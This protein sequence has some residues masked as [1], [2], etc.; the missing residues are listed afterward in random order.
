[1]SDFLGLIIEDDPSLAEIYKEALVFAGYRPDI[2][3]N[4]RLALEY[5]RT[6]KPDLIL[7]DLHL[8]EV[9]GKDILKKIKQNEK[10]ASTKVLITSADLLMAEELRD[11]VAIVLVKPISFMQLSNLAK[12]F[13][14]EQVN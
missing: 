6:V 8:P 3:A 2:V 7:L 5:L 11:D 12:R 13:L 1:M 9:S 14:P 10:L 4:G